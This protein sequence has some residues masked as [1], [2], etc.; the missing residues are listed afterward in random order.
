MDGKTADLIVTAPPYNVDYEGSN[1]L[2]IQND[3]M[4][5]EQFRA[6]LVAAFKRMH[7]V[8]KPGHPVLYMARGD[9][10]R[11]IQVGDK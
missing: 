5:E 10:R 6:F 8:V 9:D 4:P 1:G 11:R 7:E 2:T 3:D